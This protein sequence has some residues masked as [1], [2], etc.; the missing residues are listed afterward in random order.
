MALV[1]L[2]AASGAFAQAVD[3]PQTGQARCYNAA[4]AEIACAGTG[5]DGDIQAG[6]AW[7]E[8]RFTDNYNGTITDNL[9]GLVWLKEAN[10]SSAPRNWNEALTNSSLMQDGFCGLSDGSQAGDWRLP[11][12]NE[13]QSLFNAGQASPAAWLMSQGFL[14][15]QAGRYWSS[16][17][18]IFQETGAWG[19][20]LLDGIVAS[21]LKTD[22]YF[23]LPVKGMANGPATVA[24]TGQSQDYAVGDD[25]DLQAGVAWPIPRFTDN[26]DGTV[27]DN[28]TG[29]VWLK[30]ASC[31]TRDN[32]ISWIDTFSTVRNL[33]ANMCGLTDGSSAGDWRL[34]SR[35]ELSSL[36]DYKRFNPVL[37]EG[38]PFS[39]VG[40]GTPYWTS[41]TYAFNTENAWSLSL[42]SG[43]QSAMIKIGPTHIW[44]VRGG[45]LS[46]PFAGGAGSTDDPYQIETADQL[47][48]VRN[49][50]DK[51]FILTADI[52]LDVA[53]YNV[54]EG[55]QPI[56]NY[57][58]GENP[59]ADAFAGSLDGRGHVI[60][61]LFIN[62]PDQ[63]HV[64]LFGD[65]Y[66][67][68]FANLKLQVEVTGRSMVGGLVGNLEP[69]SITGVHVTG[70]VTGTANEV[71]GLAG[72][73]REANI[74][75][76]SANAPISGG[77]T[78]FGGGS[79]LGGLVGNVQND[80]SIADC[81]AYGS[82]SVNSP[83][84]LRTGGL[85]GTLWASTLERSFAA[86]DVVGRDNVGGLVGHHGNSSISSSYATGNVTPTANGITNYGG[87]VG[88]SDS[89]STITN[90]FASGNVTGSAMVGGLIGR[91][92]ADSSV[93]ASYAVGRVTGTTDDV[94]GLIGFNAGGNVTASYYDGTTSGQADAGKGE[95]KTTDALRQQA[96]FGG[97][98]FADTWNI[99][100][101]ATYPLLRWQKYFVF[102]GTKVRIVEDDGEVKS[103]YVLTPAGAAAPTTRVQSTIAD[104]STTN[105]EGVQGG[106]KAETRAGSSAVRAV[107]ATGEAGESRTWFERNNGGTWEKVSSTLGSDEAA[108]EAG[109]EIVVEEDAADG[110][111]IRIEARVT[112]ELHF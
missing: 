73:V 98:D 95:A 49:Y 76:S 46:H 88:S 96:T 79:D 62:R 103:G 92:T 94:G 55:W 105:I 65:A 53:P 47:N 30:D 19:I 13:M 87:L 26:Q 107:A 39:N 20:S 28:L 90:A 18:Y 66:R 9:T 15:V 7:P 41:T 72:R 6:V 56:G 42:W 83:F 85:L 77:S 25:G 12:I 32:G 68:D 22:N 29:L 14:N 86:G 43:E 27:T 44:P 78:T 111:Q 38:H 31:L 8:P 45:T 89:G 5:Q 102:G 61:G 101:D 74:R 106:W 81:A 11:N 52:N 3:L 75:S 17:T 60:A 2:L 80:S 71:G 100:E 109:S 99:V 16:T 97:W 36:I 67:A 108:F 112:R 63:T 23:Y 84:S 34:P 4:G 91:Q 57:S 37:P 35:Q 48:A 10:C 21:R 110:L 33:E 54:G 93:T 59:D 24:R 70:K 40:I 1:L 50:L 69:G 104:A 64:G 51:H 58:T 82:I